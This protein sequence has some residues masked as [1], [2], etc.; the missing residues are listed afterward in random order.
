[1][2]VQ[3]GSL[4]RQTR[5]LLMGAIFAN[6]PIEPTVVAVRVGKIYFDAPCAGTAGTGDARPRTSGQVDGI[7][8]AGH[9]EHLVARASAKDLEISM[10]D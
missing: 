10:R 7:G 9:A 2:G 4:S 8:C 3:A 1:M 6:A 5:A